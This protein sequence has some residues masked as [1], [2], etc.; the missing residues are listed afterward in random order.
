MFFCNIPWNSLFD[1]IPNSYMLICILF[2][3]A[4]PVQETVDDMMSQNAFAYFEGISFKLK[5]HKLQNIWIN[6]LQ[7]KMRD[8]VKNGELNL[9]LQALVEQVVGVWKMKI[10][11]M[12]THQS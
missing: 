5:L 11:Q 10:V 8:L 12:L 1:A 3:L 4:V 9:E 2:I 7:V 6:L